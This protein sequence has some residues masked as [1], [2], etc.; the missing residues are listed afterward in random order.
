MTSRDLP[1]RSSFHDEVNAAQNILAAGQG[2]LAERIVGA[3][4]TGW[5]LAR[6]HVRHLR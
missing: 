1:L 3:N 2:R 4:S 6:V 5:A